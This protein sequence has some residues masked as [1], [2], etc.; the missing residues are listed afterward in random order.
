M[1]KK[2]KSWLIAII[3]VLILGGIT[4]VTVR[5]ISSSWEDQE[6]KKQDKEAPALE[7]KD[8]TIEKGHTYSLYDFV[9]SCIDNKS[10]DCN[11]VFSSEEMTNFTEIGTYDITVKATDE[12]G[13]ETVKTAKLTIQEVGTSQE[14]K[15][16]ET[17]E[18]EEQKKENQ[19]QET[20]PQNQATKN[21]TTSEETS[22]T[23]TIYGTTCEYKITTNYDTY[24]DGSKVA[25]GKTEAFVGCDYT[26]YHASIEE[27]SEEAGVQMETYLDYMSSV[28]ALL[29]QSRIENGYN[30]ISLEPLLTTAAEYRSLEAG[31][32]GDFSGTRVNSTPTFMS[33][34]GITYGVLEYILADELDPNRLV[35]SLLSEQAFTNYFYNN[36]IEKIGIGI[37]LVHNRYIWII[38]L[39]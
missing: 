5:F 23:R 1:R 14:E 28:Y 9:S 10:D 4:F 11:L 6:N 12:S 31:Y 25:T 35:A 18:T 7:L 16:E 30:G 22:E 21:G 19:S 13:N 2:W 3:V 24:T 29:Y 33:E 15:K 39:A 20:P 8:V 17:N 34:L 26:N 36:E 37:A 38:Y 27:L 32:S